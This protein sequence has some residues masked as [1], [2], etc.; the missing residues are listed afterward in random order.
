MAR[1][2]QLKPDFFTDEDLAQLPFECRLLYEGLW[3]LADREGRLE[4]R[5]LKIKVSVLPYDDVSIDAL[6]NALAQPRQ[7]APG[8]FIERYTSSGRSY[9]QI[10]NFEKHQN[11]H[12]KEAKST[13]PPPPRRAKKSNDKK[14]QKKISRVIN[15]GSSGSSIP[16]G[17][18]GSS[19]E[20]SHSGKPERPAAWF[21]SDQSIGGSEEFKTE[22]QKTYP[23]VDFAT[24]WRKANQWHKSAPPSKRKKHAKRFILNWFEREAHAAKFRQHTRAS[25]AKDYLESE[26]AF[27]DSQRPKMTPEME[28]K[29]RE[30]GEK[31]RK[32]D[33]EQLEKRKREREGARV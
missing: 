30:S 28:K 33:A 22:L 6:L 9:I 31:R 4:D 27:Y 19:R 7:H 32:Y 15:P 17:S 23:E 13:L 12:P 8:A 29:Y 1:A 21:N 24:T 2:R 20:E 3:T 5:P 18:T 25:P 16:S 11:P 26:Q 14:R 10:N